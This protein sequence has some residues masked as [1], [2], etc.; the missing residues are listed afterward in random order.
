MTT[1]ETNRREFYLQ[2]F[3]YIH[4]GGID[5]KRVDGKHK[6][7]VDI[8][9]EY[10]E[11]RAFR[12]VVR[13]LFNQARDVK[14]VGPVATEGT[15]HTTRYGNV[16]HPD[17]LIFQKNP[18]YQLVLTALGEFK[19]FIMK[20]EDYEEKITGFVELINVLRD[21]PLDLGTL[22]YEQIPP[23][24]GIPTRIIIPPADHMELLFV[25]PKIPKFTPHSSNLF[26]RVS[27][28]VVGR[29]NWASVG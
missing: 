16:R 5:R 6:S 13:T 28:Q 2:Q 18:Q 12:W 3:D 11:D 14:L 1:V 20:P 10:Y 21:H 24:W 22:L 17:L 26:R 19:S 4:P 8:E 7:I 23:D 27:H 25:T 9:A 15:F 29:P